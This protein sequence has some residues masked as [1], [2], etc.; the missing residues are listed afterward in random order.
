LTLQRLPIGEGS[1][2]SHPIPWGGAASGGKCRYLAEQIATF[3]DDQL[4]FL[5]DFARSD[6]EIALR[7][8]IHLRCD[9]KPHATR[10]PRSPTSN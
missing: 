4:R 9:G 1:M 6:R 10:K 3:T 7:E 2:S 8:A 5:V